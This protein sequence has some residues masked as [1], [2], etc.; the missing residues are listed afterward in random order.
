[1]HD[2]DDRRPGRRRVVGAVA[3][4]GGGDAGHPRSAPAPCRRAGT[5]PRRPGTAR[6]PGRH[7]AVMARA[8]RAPPVW[9]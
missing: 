5:P 7:R 8:T 6:V 1:P 3:G 9:V 2:H 4:E